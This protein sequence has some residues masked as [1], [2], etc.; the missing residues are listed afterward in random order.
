MARKTRNLM[1]TEAPEVD[2]IRWAAEGCGVAYT[3]G[4]RRSYYGGGYQPNAEAP[5]SRNPRAI[6]TP[7]MNPFKVRGAKK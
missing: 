7:N 1:P 5:K 6:Y 2:P 3:A 4:Q